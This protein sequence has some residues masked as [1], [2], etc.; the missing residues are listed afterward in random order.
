MDVIR[1]CLNVIILD[2]SIM[3]IDESLISKLSELDMMLKNIGNRIEFTQQE[4][5][6][7]NNVVQYDE[8]D[9]TV[10]A[11]DRRDLQIQSLQIQ[12]TLD[13]KIYLSTRALRKMDELDSVLLAAFIEC[14]RNLSKFDLASGAKVHLDQYKQ[15][16][17]SVY[18]K[19]KSVRAEFSIALKDFSEC[20]K[21]L[22]D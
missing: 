22:I 2:D 20:R 10:S 7:M 19:Y 11:Q 6:A 13:E 9:D 16:L 5:R 3:K 17:L 12:I 21:C 8:T 18:D 4:T 15:Y 14:D 1:D